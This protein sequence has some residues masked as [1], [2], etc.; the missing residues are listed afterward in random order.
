MREVLVMPKLGESV[1]EGTVL[2]WLRRS[3][4]RVKVDESVVEVETEKVNVEIPSSW[5]GEL[6][7]VAGEGETVPVGAPLAYVQTAAAA[8]PAG[9]VPPAP[10]RQPS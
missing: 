10:V 1:T 2:K 9:L 3:G 6:Q 5:E 7:I 4:D 8:T